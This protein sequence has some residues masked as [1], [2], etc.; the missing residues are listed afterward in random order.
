VDEDEG[1]ERFRLRRA[2]HVDEGIEPVAL[3]HHVTARTITAY[4]T[5]AAAMTRAWKTSW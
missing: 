3:G 1:A 5:A 4:C 2:A